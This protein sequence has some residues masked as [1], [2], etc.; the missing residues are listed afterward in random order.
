MAG[1]VLAC[2]VS[3][4]GAQLCAARERRPGGRQESLQ[5]RRDDHARRPHVTFFSL[6][7]NLVPGD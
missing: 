1:V 2:P 7:D 4:D 6:A 5:L 3:R